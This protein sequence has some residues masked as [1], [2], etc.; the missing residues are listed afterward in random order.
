MQPIG[1]FKTP[2]DSNMKAG[3]GPTGPP[4]AQDPAGQEPSHQPLLVGAG[5]K[6]AGKARPLP[7]H[8]L[9]SF[10]RRVCL[11]TPGCLL[12]ESLSPLSRKLAGMKQAVSVLV[13]GAGSQI[14]RF[15]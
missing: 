4:E 14:P 13:M 11:E 5:P 15:Q 10:Q 12:V 8:L 3:L 7:G 1:I 9:F 6:P 2:D